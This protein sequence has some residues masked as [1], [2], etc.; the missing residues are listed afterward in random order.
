VSGYKHLAPEVKV[1][2]GEQ[3][4]DYLRAMD[5]EVNVPFGA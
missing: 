3:V 2:I 1:R 4:A 5:T